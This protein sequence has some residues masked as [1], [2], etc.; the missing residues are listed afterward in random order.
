MKH[1][2]QTS[3]VGKAARAAGGAR[4]KS[5][6]TQPNDFDRKR[7]ER[8]ITGRKRYRYVSPTVRVVVGGYLVQSPNC[9]RNIDP[10]G[11]VIDIALLRYQPG[12]RPWWL[13]RWERDSREWELQCE[14]AGLPELLEYLIHDPDREFWR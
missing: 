7:I 14:Y 12:L 2:M 6:G 5:S 9:S 11:G 3:K 1:A 8:A 13:F 4:M 10:L